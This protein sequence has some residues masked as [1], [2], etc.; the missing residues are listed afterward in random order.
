MQQVVFIASYVM[1]TRSVKAIINLFYS[2]SLSIGG[3]FV[4]E[5]EDI[6]NFTYL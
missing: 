4:L 3:I 5:I 6:Q 2:I 1:T